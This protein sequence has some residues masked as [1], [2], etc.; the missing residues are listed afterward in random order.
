VGRFQASG[1]CG[2][3]VLGMRDEIEDSGRSA[4]RRTRP[5]AER[6]LTAFDVPAKGLKRPSADF[7]HTRNST[8]ASP[9]T[10]VSSVTPAS[11]GCSRVDGPDFPVLPATRNW[12]FQFRPTARR[13]R[14]VAE[15]AREQVLQCLERVQGDRQVRASW[16]GKAHSAQMTKTS[17]TM[18]S[19]D[20]TG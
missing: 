7:F 13:V 19:R 1:S 8:A 6:E 2:R 3:T 17:I 5:C 9:T 10:W 20:H 4:R 15:V 12:R 11:S 18:I 16:R 14:L